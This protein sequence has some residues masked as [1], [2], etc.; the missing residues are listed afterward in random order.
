MGIGAISDGVKLAYL[1]TGGDDFI[2]RPAVSR[3]AAF[4]SSWVKS[5]KPKDVASAAML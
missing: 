2:Q 1:N 5:E 3:I 4:K